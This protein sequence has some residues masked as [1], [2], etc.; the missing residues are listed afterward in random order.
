MKIGFGQRK[1]GFAAFLAVMAAM[2]V[3]IATV[4]VEAATGEPMRSGKVLS[5]VHEGVWTLIQAEDD[6]GKEFWVW[7]TPCVI[8]EGGRVE[9][10]TGSHHEKIKSEK[11]DRVFEDCYIAWTLRINGKELQGMRA[12]GMPEGCVVVRPQ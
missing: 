5:A 8:G 12:H 1:V 4:P 11:F 2:F 6:Q 10:L 7:T 3:A 9:V